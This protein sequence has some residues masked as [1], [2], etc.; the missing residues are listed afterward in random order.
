MNESINSLKKFGK[1]FYWAGRILP[2][3][4]F[5]RSADL[6][7]FCRKLDDIADQETKIVALKKLTLIKNLIVIDNYKALKGLKI[8]VPEFLKNKEIAKLAIIDLLDGLIFDQGNV[9]IK[10]N[11]ELV[12]YCYRVAGTVGVLMCIALDC[13]EKKAKKFAI[14]LGIAMQLTNVARDILEDANMGRRYLPVSRSFN[15]SPLEISEI[16]NSLRL[17]SMKNK[18]I[19]KT[20]KELIMLS[21]EY[22]LSGKQGLYFLPFRIRLPIAVASNIYREIGIILKKKSFNWYE[23]RVYTSKFKKI[24]ITFLTTLKELFFIRI[25]IPSHNLYLHRYLRKI[26]K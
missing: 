13:K 15:I 10:N 14:D 18:Y 5:K 21:E 23:G 9:N 24:K 12:K 19:T 7:F 6:Y 17:N 11:N 2:S 26:V 22:Y 25:K 3:H 20:L 1:S 8:Y 16:S 4:Y